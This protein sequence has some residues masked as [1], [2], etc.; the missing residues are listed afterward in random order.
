MVVAQC[1]DATQANAS[2]FGTPLMRPIWWDFDDEKAL[3]AEETTFMFGPDYFVSN[4][5]KCSIRPNLSNSS[6][7]L[8]A[9]AD[10]TCACAKRDGARR[11]FPRGRVVHPFLH[12]GGI[13]RWN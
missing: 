1:N 13:H 12:T 4:S 2:E 11:V 3:D 8:H 5:S 9:G 6:R 10:S 7:L